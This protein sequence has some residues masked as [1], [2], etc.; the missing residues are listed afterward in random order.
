MSVWQQSAVADVQ[1]ELRARMGVV[2]VSHCERSLCGFMA[3][4]GRYGATLGSVD[5]AEP[6]CCRICTARVAPGCFHGG[7]CHPT[8]DPAC[9]AALG[10][11]TARSPTGNGPRQN[12]AGCWRCS[13]GASCGRWNAT[14]RRAVS[15]RRGPRPRGRP[16]R[17]AR[18]PICRTRKPRRLPPLSPASQQSWT[19]ASQEYPPSM[20]RP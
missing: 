1:S 2:V 11:W 18:V 17:E 3:S 14:I 5:L 6:L 7:T 19:P 4:A 10:S 12:R 8:G 16:S 9:Q 15:C 13:P 20:D